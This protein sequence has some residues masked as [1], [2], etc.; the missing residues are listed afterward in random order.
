MKSVKEMYEKDRP[1]ERL[2]LKGPEALKKYELIAVML[3]SGVKGQDIFKISREIVK[4]LDES[5]YKNIT[6]EDLISVKGVGESKAMQI[7]ASLEL[8]KRYLI[9]ERPRIESASDVWNLLSSYRNR[10]QE[11]FLT[12]TLDGASR[13]IAKRVITVGTLNQSLVH[14]R[15]VFADAITDRAAGII[16]AHN[17]PSGELIPSIQDI[18]VTQRLKEAGNLLGIEL[19]DHLIL[20]RDGWYSF[21]EEGEL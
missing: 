4:M 20:T 8:G 18:R 1:R 6:L 11:H 15:E 14:P 10:R 12:V 17:H 2:K 16:I 13:L 19:L 9:K 3:G 5:E 21:S 7:L